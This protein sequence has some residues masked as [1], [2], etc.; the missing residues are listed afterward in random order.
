MFIKLS[1]CWKEIFI[2]WVWLTYPL[3]C[4]ATDVARTV[5]LKLS[6]ALLLLEPLKKVNI[7]SSGL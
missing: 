2:T 5:G 7:P 4:A 3:P 6:E 1:E